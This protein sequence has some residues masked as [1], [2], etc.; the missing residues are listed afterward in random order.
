MA[1]ATA[2]KEAFKIGGTSLAI[3]AGVAA[4]GHFAV[5]AEQGRS[6]GEKDL[7]VGILAL[8]FY[9]PAAGFTVIAVVS[10]LVGL[11]LARRGRRA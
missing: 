6:P 3:A 11:F 8:M 1:S 4:A 5:A 2:A 7:V 10:V 9:V